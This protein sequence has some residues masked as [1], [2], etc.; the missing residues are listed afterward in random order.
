MGLSRYFLVDLAG[1]F[2]VGAMLFATGGTTAALAAACSAAALAAIRLVTMSP[3]AAAKSKAMAGVAQGPLTRTG[4]V[5]PLNSAS[6]PALRRLSV[7]ET[8][9]ASW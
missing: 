1:R 2:L 4:T 6:S 7:E 9:A 8:L 5:T 3:L